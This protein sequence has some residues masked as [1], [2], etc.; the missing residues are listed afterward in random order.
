[1]G[2]AQSLEYRC[3]YVCVWLDGWEDGWINTKLNMLYFSGVK[4]TKAPLSFK[5]LASQKWKGSEQNRFDSNY[6]FL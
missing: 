3:V 5:E 1:M 4:I 6:Q 2:G